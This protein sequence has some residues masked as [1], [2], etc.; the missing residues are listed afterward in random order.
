[1]LYPEKVKLEPES[2]K[3]Y[4]ND[5]NEYMGFSRF[6]N[7][8]LFKK[9]DTE[10]MAGRVAAASVGSEAE[11]SKAEVLSEWNGA[12]DLGN[13]YDKALEDCAGSSL[14]YAKYP[15]IEHEIRSILKE[16]EEYHSTFEQKVVYNE[17]YRIAGSPDKFCL[18]STRKDGSFVM[19]DFKVFQK[20]DLYISRGWLKEPLQHL[21]AQKFIKIAL[22]LS[23]Y[24]FQLEELLEKRCKGLFIHLIDPNLK[25]HRKVWV[26]YMKN[27]IHM[28]LLSKKEE[29][30]NMVTKT[31][32]SLF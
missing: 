27:D 4:D 32:E 29:I 3:Y 18:T 11:R 30:L 15:E 23:Y 17:H 26:P 7:E 20:D 8:F 12:K 21:P 24:A 1:M 9:F 25:S 10:F 28:V 2:H 22:Q 13:L 14:F 19:S 31:E 16:Y 6:Y 5:G